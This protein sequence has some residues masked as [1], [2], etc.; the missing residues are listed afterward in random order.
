MAWQDRA[1]YRESNHP[2]GNPL[3]WLLNGSVSLG[4]WFGIHVRLHASLIIVTILVLLFPAGLGGAK[5][6]LTFGVLLF[7]IVLLHEFGHCIASRL[8]GG[9]PTEIM[10]SPLGGAAFV[11]A[12]RRPWANFIAVIGGPLVN[13]LICILTAGGLI[14]L[15]HSA[16][17]V[18]WNPLQSGLLSLMPTST[19]GYYLWWTFAISYGLLL[20]NLWPIFP[21]DGGQMLQSLLW[22]KMGYYRA[23]L[24]SCTIGIAGAI[25][26]G[27]VGLAYGRLLLLFIAISGL[28]TCISLRMQLK[29][30]GP[31][32]FEDEGQDY[33][34]SLWNDSP[35]T[36]GGKRKH[37]SKRALRKAQK[38]A[39]EAELEQARID[40]ILAKV[41]AQGMHSLTWLERRALHKATERQRMA[42]TSSVGR[43]H[44]W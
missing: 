44:Q 10:L 29:A 1:Y 21:L 25:I 43:K 2:S 19:L 16:G 15:N 11:D 22:V 28:M 4:T 34:A 42:E 8:V 9:N 37:L 7:T 13:V 30:A 40:A 41:S 5:N 38:H 12:P 33:S 3:M 32:A 14:L 20:F 23:T 35:T 27:M 24:I 36:T 18:F 39:R 17:H 26:M 31:W 6:A